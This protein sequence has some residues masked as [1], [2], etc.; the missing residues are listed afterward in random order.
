MAS[1]YHLYALTGQE[2]RIYHLERQAELLHFGTSAISPLKRTLSV[3]D[4]LCWVSLVFPFWVAK[5]TAVAQNDEQ[6]S[7]ICL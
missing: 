1:T 6:E 7:M 2:T 3:A 4:D 5:S